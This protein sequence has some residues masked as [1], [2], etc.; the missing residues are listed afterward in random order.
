MSE[1]AEI[2]HS[3][4]EKYMAGAWGT[5]ERE[6]VAWRLVAEQEQTLACRSRRRA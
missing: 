6:G 5:G 2:A 3:D 4:G 1:A